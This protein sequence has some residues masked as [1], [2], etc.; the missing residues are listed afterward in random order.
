[1]AEEAIIDGI[2]EPIQEPQPS[3]KEDLAREQGWRPLEEWDKDPE[4]WVDA[5]TFLRNGE[6]M[7]RIKSQSS[8]IKKLEKKL[9]SQ[10]DTVSQLVEH[11]EKVKEAE[12]QRGLKDLK[13]LKKEAMEIGDTDTV[14]E[15]DDKIMDLKRSNETK[16]QAPKQSEEMHPDVAEW[17]DNNSWYKDDPALQGAA[18]GIISDMLAKDPS[19]QGNIREI[20]DRTTA[21]LKEEFPNKFGITRRTPRVTEPS[22]SDIQPSGKKFTA[23]HLNDQ[24]RAI[25]KRFI[26][27]G[28]M[29][30]MEEYAQQLGEIGGLDSQRGA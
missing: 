10:E 30:S 1:M 8:L 25:A 13:A 7:E 23:R 17:M 4:D 15:I 5:K 2:Q 12:Y 3:K 18:N 16:V 11:H 6:Y 19:L 27:M 26:E 14:I 21:K 9:A 20:L 24:Q 22:G 28:A 29:K